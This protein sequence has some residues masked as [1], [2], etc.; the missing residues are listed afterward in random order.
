MTKIKVLGICGSLRR[1]STNMGLLRFA[2]ANAPENVEIE[3]ADLTEV[4]FYNSDIVEKP[5]A[6]KKL[7]TQIEKADAL[8]LASA[9]YNYSLAPALKNALDWASLEPK[10]KLL[11]SKNVAILGAG[12]SMKTSRAQYHLRQTCVNLNLRPLNKP[13]IFCDA[14]SNSF[15]KEG[16]LIDEKIQKRIIRQLNELSASMGTN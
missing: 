14:F 1:L 13:E 6:V 10:N 3:I 12:G 4:P 8:I 11:S 16:S 5:E 9:E 15:D 2:Q 7:L